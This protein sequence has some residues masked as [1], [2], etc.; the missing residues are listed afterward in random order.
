M[1]SS[2]DNLLATIDELAIARDV[3]IPHDEARM[4]YALRKTRFRILE[5]SQR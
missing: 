3:G 1:A 2:R 4:R 5:S